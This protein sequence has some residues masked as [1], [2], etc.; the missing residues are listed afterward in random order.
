MICYNK[1]DKMFLYAYCYQTM[2]FITS[3]ECS[4]R[5]FV[6]ATMPFLLLMMMLFAVASL[7]SIING[8]ETWTFDWARLKENY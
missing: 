7:C 8:S 5:M 1:M 4:E 2:P 3:L 6:N